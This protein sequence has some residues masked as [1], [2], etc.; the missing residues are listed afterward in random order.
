MGVGWGEGGGLGE[1][2][3]IASDGPNLVRESTL[4]NK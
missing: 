1:V 4:V 3:R 2:I